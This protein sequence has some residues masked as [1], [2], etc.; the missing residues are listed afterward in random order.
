[1]AHDRRPSS[2]RR[3]QVS[4]VDISR[5]YFNAK[6]DAERPAFVELPDEDSDKA[7]GMCGQLDYH[8]YG[9]RP[10][11]KGWHSE[12]SGY[13][14]EHMGFTMGDAS[15]CVFR[16]LE[17]GLWTSVYGDDFTTTGSKEELD[18]FVEQLKLRYELTESA[19]LGPGAADDKE[20]RVL[21]RTLRWTAAGLEY[22]ADPRQVEKLVRDLG[23]AG[24]NAVSTPGLKASKEE[25]ENDKPL[26]QDKYTA[27]RAV[28]A[29]S[30]YLSADRPECQFAAKEICRW[31]SS[32][33]QLGA[34]ALKRV[35]RFLEGKRRLVIK[36]P[37]QQVNALDVYTDTDW[38]G[39]VRTRKS[40]SGG[41][42]VLGSHLIK[43]WS[44]T[45]SSVALS[46]GEAEYYGAVR[47]GG[48]GLGYQSLLGDLGIR[49]PI[50]VWTD[51]TATIG[52]CGRD[53]LG[54]L[55]HIDTQCLW[56][57]QKVRD[58][59]LEIRKVKGT[60]NPADL[61]TKH[62]GSAKVVENLLALFGCEY[63]GGRP[64]NAPS[65]RTEQGTEAGEKLNLIQQCW[66]R[67]R[68]EDKDTRDAQV[69]LV[70]SAG[71]VFPS[72]EWED[73]VVPE[74]LSYRQDKLPHQRSSRERDRLFP[75]AV[76]AAGPGD[77]DLEREPCAM[78]QRGMAI[79]QKDKSNFKVKIPK[80][81][82]ST[83]SGKV[84][85]KVS[86]REDRARNVP[87]CMVAVS[88]SGSHG[89]EGDKRNICIGG[90][91]VGEDG[92]LVAITKHDH[93]DAISSL[94]INSFLSMRTKV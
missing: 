89:Q 23:L 72:T 88:T 71:H 3:T 66:E 43:S 77:L 62:L 94:F 1:M 61:F 47:A 56:L 48:V 74:A 59:S 54:K 92:V 76:A 45:Q 90:L 53:G 80:D 8:M 5:A 60:E 12:Y 17:R 86:E 55:R 84:E 18:W 13:L 15:A 83:E 82:E 31:M 44:S 79:V 32:P 19:R 33:T 2:S 67:G 9:T 36:Y 69:H 85:P 46:S 73:Q 51:S 91:Q 11:G 70:E 21:N 49:L 41:G 93:T 39:C 58:G 6:V 65:L 10:A 20:A 38:A 4:V 63:R 42:L 50:R 30:N 75:K 34:T 52:I 35:G 57:Q 27:F 26:A 25:V 24:A 81:E 16:H 40:T 78:S 7:K 28:A 29:R 64:A 68:R 14:V 22:E 37:W 87:S